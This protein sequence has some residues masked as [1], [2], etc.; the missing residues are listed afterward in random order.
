MTKRVLFIAGLVAGLVLSACASTASSAWSQATWLS[1]TAQEVNSGP[2]K[3]SAAPLGGDGFKLKLSV[4]TDQIFGTARTGGP[5]PTP[6]EAALEEAAIA[7]TP[8]GCVFVALERT[9]D[10]GAVADYDCG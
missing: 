7:A 5:P 6:D 8:E 4:T 1:Q 3:L 9:E 2:W 10:G